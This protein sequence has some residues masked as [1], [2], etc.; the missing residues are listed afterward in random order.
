MFGDDDPYSS[1]FE[2]TKAPYSKKVS[3]R[4]KFNDIIIIF[5]FQKSF[6]V[7]TSSSSEAD[8]VEAK[9]VLL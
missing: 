6:I 7:I 1:D 5:V 4:I 8:E 9:K 2:S 3:Y